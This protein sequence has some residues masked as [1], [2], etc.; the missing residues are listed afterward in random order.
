MPKMDEA[1][2]AAKIDSLQS[3]LTQLITDVRTQTD[4]KKKRRNRKIKQAD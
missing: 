2:K 1:A 4:E 3:R